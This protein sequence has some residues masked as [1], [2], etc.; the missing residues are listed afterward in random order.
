MKS[1]PKSRA[2]KSNR[3][4]SAGKARNK[5]TFEETAF[6][7]R[8]TTRLPRWTGSALRLLGAPFVFLYRSVR[9]GKK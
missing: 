3:T 2:S 1:R 5:G 8:R 7:W 6:G 9:S 4:A